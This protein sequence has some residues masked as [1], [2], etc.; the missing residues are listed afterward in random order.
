MFEKP[1]KEHQWLDQFAG[2]WSFEGE[3]SMGPD[4]PPMK[5]TGKVSARSLGGMW[6]IIETESPDPEGNVWT[7]LMTLGYDLKKKQYVGTFYGSMGSYLWHYTGQLD[8]AGRVLTLDTE[9][10]RFDHQE[11][12][13]KYQDI[14]E[15]VS[16]DHWILRSQIL[17]DDG[18]WQPF[19]RADYR[20]VE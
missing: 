4:Q 19:M 15:V 14:V 16:P 13:S 5:S 2:Q 9:G 18:A 12:L 3:C 11:G 20:R 8:A 10:P 17:T 7:S 6:I 1:E